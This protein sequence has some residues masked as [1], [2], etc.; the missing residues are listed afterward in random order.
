MPAY[1]YFIDADLIQGEVYLL[2]AEQFHHLAHVMRMQKG[3]RVE[4]IN[5][6][7]QLATGEIV[8]MGKTSASIQVS[9][10]VTSPP[11]GPHLI[12]A[13]A[14]CRG[15]RLATIF[16]K[17]TEL[18][19]SEIWLFG[20]ERS[21]SS[22][23]SE[24]SLPRYKTITIAALKQCGRLQLPEIF[25]KPPL[26]AWKSLPAP[27]FFGDLTP[28]APPLADLLRPPVAKALLIIGP[29][30]GFSSREVDHLH[31]L[32]AVGVWLHPNILRVD[33]AAL[34]GLALISHLAIARCR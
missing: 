13:Q 9:T 21:D 15:P 20:S 14:I 26:L 10:V 24:K 1:R 32:Q 12:L 6:R 17:S 16:E 27:A 3:E 19:A 31:H 22:A 8:E 30:S 2:E 18:G 11:Q 29:E 7:R 5:G 28:G 25:S 23:L 4:L 34:V 33:T